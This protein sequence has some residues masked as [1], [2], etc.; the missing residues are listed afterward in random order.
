MKFLSLHVDSIKFKATKKALKDAP[1]VDKKEV[2]VKDALVIL[3]GVEKRDETN[4]EIVVEFVKNVKD[5]ARQVKATKIVLYPYAHLSSSLASPHA[6]IE[7]L[8]K[9][10]QELKKNFKVTAAPFGWYKQ[11]QVSCK[12]HPLAELS[13]EIF[14]EKISHK[15]VEKREKEKQEKPLAEDA[16]SKKIKRLSKHAAVDEKLSENDHRILGPKLGLFI[17]NEV[18]PGSVFWLNNGMLLRENLLKFWREEH[19]K[20]GYLEINTPQL[21]SRSLWEISGH[22][23]HYKNFMFF[24]KVDDKDFALKPMNCPG[25]VIVYKSEMRSYRDLP[26]RLAEIGTVS[27]NELSGVLSGLFR[28]RV[29]TQDDAHLY[30]T[31]NQIEQEISRVIELVNKFYKTFGF[32][33]SVELST[34]P[35]K[36][37]GD[38]KLWDKAEKA[39][40]AALKKEKISFKINKGDGAFYGPKID[41]H[42][43]DSQDRTWQLAT[44]QLD[45]QMPERFDLSYVDENG[46]QKRPVI[47]HRVIFGALERFVGILIE[48]YKGNFPLW[49]AP[50]QVLIANIS[51]KNIKYAKQIEAKLQEAGIRVK[52]NYDNKTVE[53]KV[54][55]TEV[56]KI[57]YV[58]IVGEKEEKN[59]T[60]AVR[61]KGK[62]IFNVKLEEFVKQILDEVEKKK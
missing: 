7:I 13:R 32:A 14:S 23:E 19:R 46:K 15:E 25:S 48:H 42:I 56:Q 57:P 55:E 45:F 60:I 27:R 54:R 4:P 11:F 50:I 2:E 9:A 51:E 39:L 29:F 5:I 17:F 37:L 33:Y 38:R 49:L 35:E 44:I 12:G 16:L 58:V 26:L 22:Y 41:F 40:E 43:K 36:A 24:T 47:I 30:V 3:T 31:P 59:K 28:L 18:S 8:K 1:D 21:A 62:V 61:S 53:Y 10:E 20:A 52:A 6:A 34:R